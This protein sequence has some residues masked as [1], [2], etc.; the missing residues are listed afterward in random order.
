[1]PKS[2]S[3]VSKFLNLVYHPSNF[4]PLTHFSLICAIL[5]LV[6]YTST[7]LDCFLLPREVYVILHLL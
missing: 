2:L 1:M 4:I 7:V 3:N 5:L 6:H